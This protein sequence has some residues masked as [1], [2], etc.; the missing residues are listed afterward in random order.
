ME[1]YKREQLKQKHQQ[2]DEKARDMEKERRSM[3]QEVC[4]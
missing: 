1:A 2:E 4:L 3:L